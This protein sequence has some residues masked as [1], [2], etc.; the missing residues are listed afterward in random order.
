M[1]KLL[2]LIEGHSKMIAF[3]GAGGKTT[4]IYNLANELISQGKRVIITTTTHI[5]R[6]ENIEIATDMEGIQKALQVNKLLVAGKP[7]EDG[8]LTCLEE[9]IL[10][11]L[12][13]YADYVLIEADG[14]KRMP[15]KV[16]KYN[17][18]VLPDCIDL[19]VGIVGMDCIGK[20]IKDVC[21]RPQ[22]AVKL[23]NEEIKQVVNENHFM[24]E[25][26]VA[27]IITSEKGL[28]KSVGQK[29]FK[30]IL[31]KVDN[32]K[33]I[34]SAEKII[35]ILELKGINDCLMTSYKVNERIY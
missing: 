32:E 8:K 5:Y 6:P 19:I 11:E 35:E 23:L 10:N 25:E 20:R 31:N 21:F 22:E 33:N 15:I 34:L 14:A 18:P 4:T 2:A 27:Q 16:P 26:H 29:P 17:E 12:G 13:K 1:C 9:S 24:T 7:C 3:V 30:V 28:R